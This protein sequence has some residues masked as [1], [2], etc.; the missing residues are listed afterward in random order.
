LFTADLGVDAVTA[1]APFAL[2]PG[3]GDGHG[4]PILLRA[5]P[6]LDDG[7]VDG[8]AF[9]RT[10]AHASAEA[11]RWFEHG[12]LIR[13]G[14]A[15]FTDAARA[16][17]GLSAADPPTLVDVGGGLRVRIPGVAGTVRVDLGVG[18]RDGARAASVGWQK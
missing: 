13:L 2:W 17:R 16:S 6:L 3:A 8:P 9:G 11:Q 5:H 4:R 10:L 14:V 7:V 12:K 1:S 18:V 15:G